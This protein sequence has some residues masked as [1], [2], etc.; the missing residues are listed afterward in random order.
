MLIS[1]M[2]ALIEL[3]G[4]KH[5][6]AILLLQLWYMNALLMQS[7]H[8]LKQQLDELETYEWKSPVLHCETQCYSYGDSGLQLGCW[9]SDVDKEGG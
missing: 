3:K 5:I 2:I 4:L 1:C 9:H 6:S 8:I 7:H